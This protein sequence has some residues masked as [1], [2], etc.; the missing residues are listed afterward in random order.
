MA[1]A[2]K[3][4]LIKETFIILVIILGNLLIHEKFMIYLLFFMFL[5]NDDNEF[6]KSK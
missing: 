4:H 3:V 2:G 5:K 6:V 1:E